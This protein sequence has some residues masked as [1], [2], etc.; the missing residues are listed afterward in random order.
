MSLYL[1]DII[2]GSG[3]YKSVDV[4][5]AEFNPQF[6]PSAVDIVVGAMSIGRNVS[7]LGINNRWHSISNAK[8]KE[9]IVLFHIG[10]KKFL[11]TK[12]GNQFIYFFFF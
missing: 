11:E 4:Y 12:V 7:I 10:N 8:G 1:Q 5:L 9:D 2:V 3:L 6:A